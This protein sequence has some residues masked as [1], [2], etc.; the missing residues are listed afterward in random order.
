MPTE[1]SFGLGGE[2]SA[3]R[4]GNYPAEAGKECSIRRLEG[5]AGHLPSEDG[6]LVAE[7]DDPDGQIGVVGPLQSEDLDGPEEGEIEE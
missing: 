6:H 1:Q 7:H 5:R 4:S 2:P 3:L